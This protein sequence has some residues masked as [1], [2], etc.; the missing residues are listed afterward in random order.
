MSKYT[1]LRSE[2]EWV[3]GEYDDGKERIARFLFERI[4]IDTLIDIAESLDSMDEGLSSVAGSL[5][6]VAE[7][8]MEIAANLERIERGGL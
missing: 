2:L 8:L 4:K 3:T 7:S 6:G 5:T 1:D